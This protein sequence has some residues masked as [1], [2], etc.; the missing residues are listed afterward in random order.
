MGKCGTPRVRVQG[1]GENEAARSELLIR[2]HCFPLK[3][4]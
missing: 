4:F 3:G 2:R 1:S